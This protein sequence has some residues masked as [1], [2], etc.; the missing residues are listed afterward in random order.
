MRSHAFACGVLSKGHSDSGSGIDGG[1][2][3]TFWLFLW[4]YGTMLH[5]GGLLPCI[6]CPSDH[7]SQWQ[8]DFCWHVSWHPSEGSGGA[9]PNH[10]YPGPWSLPV[11]IMFVPGP[12]DSFRAFLPLVAN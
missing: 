9:S 2:Q 6:I 8:P 12:A 4:Q 11:S 10:R 3:V 7:G 5:A 1:S